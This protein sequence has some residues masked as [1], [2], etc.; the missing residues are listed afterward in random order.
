MQALLVHNPKAGRGEPSADWL[1]EA[2]RRLGY[3]TTYCNKAECENALSGRWDL[4]VLAGGDGTVTKAIRHLR[5]RSTPI[6]ILPTGTANNVARSLGLGMSAEAI[7]NGLPNAPT[8]RLDVGIVEGNGI[9]STFL[10]AVGL[11]AVAHSIRGGGDK[12]PYG[13][14]IARGREALCKVIEE[15]E[16]HDFSLTIDEHKIEGP[17]LFVEV[18]NLRFSGPRLPIAYMAESGDGLLDVA[19]LAED[20]RDEMLAWLRRNPEKTPPP[21]TL[22]QGRKVTIAW[23]NAPLRIDD[24]AIE[25]TKKARQI[26]A[27]IDAQGLEVLSPEINGANGR[28]GSGK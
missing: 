20:Q 7:I 17:Y 4:V 25:A 9:S 28:N 10:E 16:P 15:A 2:F 24:Q 12:P 5:H 27:K 14:R 23:K 11:A 6:A 21:L 22:A 18:L 13:E 19:L 8:R 3:A 1:K 26:T